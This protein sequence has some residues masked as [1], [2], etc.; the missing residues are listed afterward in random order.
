MMRIAW[1]IAVRT[2]GSPMR[3][4]TRLITPSGAATSFGSSR[5][6]RPVSISPQVEALTNSDWLSPR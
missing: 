2:T 4:T 5:T 1:R 6:I 3:P